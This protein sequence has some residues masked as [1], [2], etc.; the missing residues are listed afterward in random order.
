MSDHN[1]RPDLPAASFSIAGTTRHRKPKEGDGRALAPDPKHLEAVDA[2]VEHMLFR[3]GTPPDCDLKRPSAQIRKHLDELSD[4]S[5]GLPFGEAYPH[6]LDTLLYGK[7]LFMAVSRPFDPA[8]IATEFD[9][10][11]GLLR[12]SLLGQPIHVPDWRT[13]TLFLPHFGSDDA[14]GRCAVSAG[15]LSGAVSRSAGG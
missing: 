14:G 15:W 10:V 5:F 8:R 11:P 3:D 1:E 6:V 7:A 4:G 12:N 2:V 9:V 13:I